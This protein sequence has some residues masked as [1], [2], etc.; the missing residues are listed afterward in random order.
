MCAYKERI[1]RFPI[2]LNGLVVRLRVAALLFLYIVSIVESWSNQHPRQISQSG[3]HKD[4]VCVS[5]LSSNIE[6]VEAV[7]IVP[8]ALSTGI[9]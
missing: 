8:V 7:V 9:L 2:H 4:I 5:S 3:Q 6:I 1:F